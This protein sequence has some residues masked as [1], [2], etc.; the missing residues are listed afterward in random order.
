MKLSF[1]TNIIVSSVLFSLLCMGLVF[2]YYEIQAQEPFVAVSNTAQVYHSL[3]NQFLNISLIAGI[4]TIGLMV[5]L[6]IKY[7]EKDSSQP[8]PH[9]VPILGRM[10][11]ERGKSKTLLFSVTVTGIILIFLVVGTFN[12]LDQIQNI[13]REKENTLTI[14]VDGFQWNW[15]FKYPNGYEQIGELRVPVNETIILDITSTDVFHNFAIIE[16]KIKIDAL[17]GRVNSIWFIPNEIGTYQI[18]CF[19]FCGAG[20]AY[21]KAELI[22]MEPEDFKEWMDNLEVEE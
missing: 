19:E 5:I 7:R 17:H 1:E 9:D 12:A 2:G 11:K 3:F 16:Y 4:I 18:Q 10:P 6:I 21:M 15:V 22:V 13:P 14:K 20:H 8:D